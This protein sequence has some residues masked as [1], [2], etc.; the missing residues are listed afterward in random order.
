MR[1]ILS[2]LILSIVALATLGSQLFAQPQPQLTATASICGT[3]N[4]C[5]VLNWTA[6]SDGAANP[7]LGYNVYKGSTAGGENIS[8]PLNGTTLSATNCPTSGA[9]TFTDN[10]VS[11]GQNVFYVV[12]ASLNGTESVASNEISVKVSPAAPSGL[13]AQVQ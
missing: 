3:G 6:S 12:K 7:T 9:C 4:H 13:T 2:C 8:T 5:V 11:V 1:T 10:S